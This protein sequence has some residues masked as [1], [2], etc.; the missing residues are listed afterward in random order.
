MIWIFA[1][2]IR[3][4]L[5]T[6]ER[7]NRPRG[8]PTV[9]RGRMAACLAGLNRDGA[10]DGRSAREIAIANHFVCVR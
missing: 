10:D 8:H 9:E 5:S 1:R 3:P 6:T 7:R 4:T 2:A